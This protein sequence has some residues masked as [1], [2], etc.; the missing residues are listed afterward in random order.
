MGLHKSKKADSKGCKVAKIQAKAVG[1][2]RVSGLGQEH[3]HGLDRQRESIAVFARSKGFELVKV[4][5]ETWTGKDAERPVFSDMLADLLAN[6]CKVVI[7]ESLDRFARDLMVQMALLGRLTT[8]GLTLYSASTGEN[9]TASIMDD[10]MREALVI[11]QGTFAM[12]D[13]KLLVRKLRKAREAKRARGER[14]EGRKP[15][16][17]EVIEALRSLRRKRKGDRLSFA[18]CAARL[19]EL[20]LPTKSGKPWQAMT[21][22]AIARREGIA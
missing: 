22:R 17:P 12:V 20:R 15:Y 18:R 3:G 21:V 19:Q 4:Y 11:V 1:Y 16:G 6:G 10:P 7:V 13:R 14:C 8:A 9:V 5:A 2:A